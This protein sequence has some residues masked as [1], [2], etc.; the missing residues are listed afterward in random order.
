VSEDRRPAS[1]DT[2]RRPAGA[3][4]VRSLCIERVIVDGVALSRTQA[5]ALHRALERELTE[6]V[7]R[8][9]GIDV[10]REGAWARV[11]APALPPLPATEPEQ[12]GRAVAQSV[13]ASLGRPT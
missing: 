2:G 12:I 6:L 9:A 5:R 8:A 7:N 3:R 11:Q 1:A 4:E 10:W 13:Y